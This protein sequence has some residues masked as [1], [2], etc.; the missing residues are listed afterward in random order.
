MPDTDQPFLVLIV[1][2]KGVKYELKDYIPQDKTKQNYTIFFDQLGF[3]VEQLRPGA[4][5]AIIEECKGQTFCV[6]V[7]ENGIFKNFVFDAKRIAYLLL[8]K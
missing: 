2:I 4:T 7:T 6:S 5:P 8:Q 3:L 1:E